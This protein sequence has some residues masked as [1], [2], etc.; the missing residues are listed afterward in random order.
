MAIRKPFFPGSNLL[1]PFWGWWIGVAIVLGI[2]FRIWNLDYKV[3]WHDE[4]YTTFRSAGY[5][6]A[7]IVQSV[8][9]ES[10]LSI[11]D[12]Q[13]FQQLKP[14]STAFNT[15]GS[16][17]R[18]DPQHAPLFFV[19]ARYWMRVFGSSVFA[20]RLLPVVISLLTLPLMY[21]LAQELF[22]SSRLA[23]F[24]TAFLALS[25]IDILFA[26]TAR[27]YSLL[28]F[29][30]IFSGWSLLRALRLN[31]SKTWLLHAVSLAFGFYSHVFFLL[32]WI[33][34]GCFV[35]WSQA[36]SKF[37]FILASGLGWLLFSPWLLVLWRNLDTALN[38]NRWSGLRVSAVRYV[39]I[40]VHSFTALVSDS[41]IFG[42]DQ[43]PIWPRLLVALFIG[44]STFIVVQSAT[45]D[46]K[47]F[48]LATSWMP[49]FLL[50]GADLLLGG[51]RSTIPRYLTGSFPGLQL[52]MA[53]GM[54]YLSHALKRTASIAW[55]IILVLAFTSLLTS[56]RAETWWNKDISYYNGQITEFLN[57]AASPTLITDLEGGSRTNLGNL[58]ALSYRL[59]KDIPLIVVSNSGIDLDIP[60]PAAQ[61]DLTLITYRP[62]KH[63]RSRLEKAGYQ[64][65]STGLPGLTYVT[66]SD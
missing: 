2:G 21:R 37:N 30:V 19:M 39:K 61:D 13:R 15:L 59:N 49:F 43:T 41:D 58:L 52:T 33:A 9:Q 28:T 4:T 17:A 29:A 57:N 16:L 32:N 44:F 27:Q 26:Q 20:S 48:V 36:H 54:T 40:W 11:G 64:F 6:S 42:S 12:L 5:F 51:S 56:A 14:G 22:A 35:L 63:L 53:Y 46:Q 65:Q 62:S 25:P 31:D 55:G 45:S 10:P 18:E 34:Q 24:A 1:T 47:Q 60:I 3:Y 38:T 7:E 8:V 50:V 23:W 66:P